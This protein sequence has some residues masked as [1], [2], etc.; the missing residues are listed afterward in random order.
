M[1][2]SGMAALITRLR[3]MAEAGTADY[4]LAGATYWSDDHLQDILDEHRRR[5]VDVLLTPRPDYVSGDEIYTRYEIPMP[6]K[7]GLEGTAGGS[8]AFRIADST[9]A[10]IAYAGYS[11]SERDLAVTFTADTEGSARY[12]SGYAYDLNAAAKDA[13]LRKAGHAWTAIDFSADGHRFDRSALHAH[14]LE[15]AKTFGREKG[16]VSGKFVR[17]D[18]AGG[19]RD[20][21][22]F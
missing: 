13:W 10:T 14:C 20:G 21:D 4:S 9:G 12:W 6:G 22:R 2:R 17:P 19:G 3:Q 7:V 18:L 15:M 11:F 8:E 5:M 1:A 16:M